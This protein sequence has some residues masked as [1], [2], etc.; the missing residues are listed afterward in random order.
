[1]PELV[2]ASLDLLIDGDAGV[3]HL[4]NEGA[5]SWYELARRCM[6]LAGL[7][8]TLVVGQ[9]LAVAGLTA[10]RPRYAALGTARGRILGSVEHALRSFLGARG[11]APVEREQRHTP[12]AAEVAASAHAE[13]TVERTIAR[14]ADALPDRPRGTAPHDRL[15]EHEDALGRIA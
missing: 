6:E 5:V 8:E 1:M 15:P 12:D 7:D 9:P 2:H 10:R 4:A 14:L 3:W 11:I 13:R